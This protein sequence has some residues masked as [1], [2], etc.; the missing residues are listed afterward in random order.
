MA[1]SDN[2]ASSPSSSVAQQDIPE[3]VN[4]NAK[5]LR[6]GGLR[7]PDD[8]PPLNVSTSA[9]NA[10]GKVTSRVSEII[11]ENWAVIRGATITALFLGGTVL[12]LQSRLT[13]RVKNLN[14][15][16]KEAYYNARRLRGVVVAVDPLDRALFFYQQPFLPRVFGFS[17]PPAHLDIKLQTIPVRLSRLIYG[18]AGSEYLFEELQRKPV[19]IQL[20]YP[21]E[22]HAY[23]LLY[24]RGDNS[25][26]RRNASRDLVKQGLAVVLDE[27][28]SL[29]KKEIREKARL[30]V[31]S[32]DRYF[33]FE[34]TFPPR[35]L[36]RFELLKWDESV[37]RSLRKGVWASIE[38]STRVEKVRR[39]VLDSLVM[40]S[41]LKAS[42]ASSEEPVPEGHE[43]ES[44]KSSKEEPPV[45]VAEKPT[46]T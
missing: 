24:Y 15:I 3:T 45:V 29:E 4:E 19:T 37:A 7:L 34:R 26:F 6:G 8:V 44:S 31:L 10:A 23:C 43:L 32:D 14:S 1:S 36:R 35:I 42:K 16:P 39:W 12:L 33:E 27:D 28:E 13:R 11:D 38:V 17:I 22:N 20:L 46:S 41:S 30:P 18:N 2:E 9:R 40:P 25:L 21:G 5:P